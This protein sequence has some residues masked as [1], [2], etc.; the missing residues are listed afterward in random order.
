MN[1]KE[2]LLRQ[3]A[4]TN[5][6][7]YENYVVTR[8]IHKLDDP[9]VKFITQQCVRRPDRKRALTDLY[10]PQIAFHVEID[11][12]HHK[13]MGEID[14]IREADIV[15]AT[16]HTI[17]R[18][19]ATLPLVELNEIIDKVIEDVRGRVH[20]KRSLQQ[21]EPWDPEKEHNPATHIERGYMDADEDVAFY[22]QA[23]ACNCF[24]RSYKG[25]QR[26][27]VRHA[28]E[29]GL[30]IW[31]P[32]LYDNPG[33]ENAISDDEETIYE[34]SKHDKDKHLHDI[35]SRT[36]WFKRLVFARVRGSLGDVMYR[37]KGL[38][39]LDI[40]S[41]KTTSILTYRRKTKRVRTYAPVKRPTILVDEYQ[42]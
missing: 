30:S 1:R 16:G 17:V 31:F 42:N 40:E 3:I 15:D 34:R 24:G 26:S 4:K 21:F 9:T 6:K 28:T 25:L 10:V 27:I 7:T 35:L 5:K 37:F 36:D 39:E 32:K 11:E 18:V 2:F 14:T 12:G 38:Y 22:R 20:A 23:D 29:T 33:W 19:D 8:I 41:S 13:A